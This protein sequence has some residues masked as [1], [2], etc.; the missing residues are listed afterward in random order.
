MFK[1]GFAKSAT[2]VNEGIIN[3]NFVI[4]QKTHVSIH[5]LRLDCY[6][7]SQNFA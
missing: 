3:Y 4:T 6:C 7:C 1:F 5:N 2:D